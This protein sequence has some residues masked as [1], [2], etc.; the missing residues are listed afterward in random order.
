ME[1]KQRRTSIGK[2]MI[3][4]LIIEYRI[5]ADIMDKESTKCLQNN[6]LELGSY[7]TRESKFPDYS[8]TG[9]QK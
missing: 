4:R 6:I 5:E 8:L 9:S 2:H 1:I 7:P 3:R